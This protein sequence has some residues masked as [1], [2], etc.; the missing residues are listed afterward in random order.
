MR[1][2]ALDWT[3]RDAK[4]IAAPARLVER[5]PARGFCACRRLL[6]WTRPHW[7]L[8][9][10]CRRYRVSTTGRSSP[11]SPCVE[12]AKPDGRVIRRDDSRRVPQPRQRQTVLLL[13]RPLDWELTLGLQP[14][15]AKT[16]LKPIV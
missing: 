14:R 10:R 3:V 16:G 8:N 9:S 7:N 2:L 1:A 15:R 13:H 11:A 6:A 4:L 12:W 5:K